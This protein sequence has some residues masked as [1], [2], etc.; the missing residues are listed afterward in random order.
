M[1]A[2]SPW[3]SFWLLAASFLLASASARA[4]IVLYSNDNFGGSYYASEDEIPNLD[5]AG[6]NDKASS[7]KVR[8]GRWEVCTD[9]NFRGTCTTFEPG[10][11]SSLRHYGLN[12]KISSVRPL[13]RARW[14]EQNVVIF[15]NDN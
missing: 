6:F 7:L 4:E 2:R 8:H 14:K 15:K 5:K 11:Y 10:E 3:R 12:D 1:A 9:A 13:R